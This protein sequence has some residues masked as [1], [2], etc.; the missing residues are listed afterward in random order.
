MALV[1]SGQTL[2]VPALPPLLDAVQ[3]HMEFVCRLLQRQSLAQPHYRLRPNP[4]PWMRM[5]YAHFTQCLL[6]NLVQYQ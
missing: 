3:M 5:K 4:H 2:L 6:L 1:Q